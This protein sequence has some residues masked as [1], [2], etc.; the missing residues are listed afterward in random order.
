[1][2]KLIVVIFLLLIS[3]NL[4]AETYVYLGMNTMD[5]VY[6]G[7][8]LNAEI[9]FGG[10]CITAQVSTGNFKEYTTLNYEIGFKYYFQEYKG[11]NLQIAFPKDT[12][13]YKT[14]S[15]T[16]PPS[17]AMRIGWRQLM[18][19]QDRNKGIALD[20][21]LGFGCTMGFTSIWPLA[22]AGIGYQF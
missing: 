3:I 11:F 15:I 13:T 1:M 18:T 17:L 19:I 16:N 9:L 5:F 6:N 20:A 21:N 2:K 8:C 14:Y 12:F 4:H 22:V 10:P 7:I